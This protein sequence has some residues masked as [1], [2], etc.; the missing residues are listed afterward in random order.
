MPDSVISKGKILHF[1]KGDDRLEVIGLS[2]D[3]AKAALVGN[4]DV[5][6]PL[7]DEPSTGGTM[8]IWTVGGR[9][10]RS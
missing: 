3:E 4:R 1:D 6:V 10:T 9:G 8:A 2:F 7:G 5:M